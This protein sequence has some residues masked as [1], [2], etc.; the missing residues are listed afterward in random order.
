MLFFRGWWE[1]AANSLY[2]GEGKN[3]DATRVSAGKNIDKLI[4]FFRK[5]ERIWCLGH[6]T[7]TI[8]KLTS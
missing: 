8:R 4:N 7:V 1:G 5:K 2:T 3:K 6:M